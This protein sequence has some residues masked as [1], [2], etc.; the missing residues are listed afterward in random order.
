[1][2]TCA[3]CGAEFTYTGKGNRSYCSPCTTEY[4]R[5]W[6]QDNPEAVRRHKKK[7]ESEHPDEVR[8]AKRRRYHADLERSRAAQRDWKER[9]PERI[10]VQQQRRLAKDH[11]TGRAILYRH[12]ITLEQ[13]AE[14]VAAQ[15]GLCALCPQPL[16]ELSTRQAHI[17]HD[18]LTELIRGILC[19][20]CNV[21]LGWYER[22]I[23]LVAQYLAGPHM[24]PARRRAQSRRGEGPVKYQRW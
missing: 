5:Q 22:R 18:H 19:N 7:W 21:R 2:K 6:R 1:M 12:G 9:N 10:R 16:E 3:R 17:D 13:R 4:K 14:L 15:G 11:A 8:A 24:I 23:E 20:S